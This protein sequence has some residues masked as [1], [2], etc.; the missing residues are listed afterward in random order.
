MDDDP[1]IGLV[2][3]TAL[4][5]LAG[6]SVEHVLDGSEAVARAESALPELILLDLW[7]GDVDGRD[8]LDALRRSPALAEV[9]VIFLTARTDP[10]ETKALEERGAIAVIAKPFDPYRLPAEIERALAG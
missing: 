8:V 7:L 10:A 6:H 9:P 2:V 4:E 5:R 1:E 3:R